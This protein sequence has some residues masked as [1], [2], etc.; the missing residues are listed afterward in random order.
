MYKT[1]YQMKVIGEFETL[2]QAFKVIYDAIKAEK[3]LLWQVLETT[4]WIER[5]ECDELLAWYNFYDA[6]D[7]MCK[8]GFLVDGKW[9]D[10]KEG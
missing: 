9:V 3:I 7:E 1:T 5:I 2:A 8:Q 10:K 4:I 6:R